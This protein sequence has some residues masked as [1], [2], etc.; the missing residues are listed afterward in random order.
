MGSKLWQENMAAIEMW[1]WDK[2]KIRKITFLK[3]NISMNIFIYISLNAKVCTSRA[4]LT[5]LGLHN[6]MP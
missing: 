4:R 5:I 6:P 2:R 1:L 3:W